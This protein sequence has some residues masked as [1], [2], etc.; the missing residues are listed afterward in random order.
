M[1]LSIRKILI[2]RIIFKL[3]I[4]FI[5]ATIYFSIKAQ[6]NIKIGLRIGNQAPNFELPRIDDTLLSLESLRGKIVLIDFWASW[7][8]SCRNKLSTI[9]IYNKYKDKHFK[10]AEGFVVLSVSFDKDK[11]VWIQA[12]EKDG[13]IWNTHVNDLTGFSSDVAKL[14]KLSG[15]PQ[16]ILLDGNGIILAKNIHS[17]SLIYK[18][19]DMLIK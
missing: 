11:S 12:I 15:L 4:L 19:D 9:S 1:I 5:L 10:T 3:L 14:Y 2:V 8:K 6:N 17:T 13:L 18:L 7:C 16:N